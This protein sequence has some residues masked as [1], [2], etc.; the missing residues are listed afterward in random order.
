MNPPSA[1]IKDH[2]VANSSFVFGTDLFIGTQPDDPDKCLTLYDVPA[3]ESNPKLPIEEVGIQFRS[4]STDYVEAYSIISDMKVL[5]EGKRQDLMLN[6][7]RYFSFMVISQP[8]QLIRDK[9]ERHMFAM[10]MY[11]KRNPSN[12]G[13]RT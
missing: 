3:N 12:V 10:T 11:L 5:L 4:R 2:I 8:I 13:E 1:D 6:G 7:S 9:K